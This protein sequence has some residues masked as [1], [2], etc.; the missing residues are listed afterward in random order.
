[1]KAKGVNASGIMTAS[2]WQRRKNSYQSSGQ[3]GAEVKNY[4]TYKAYLAAITEYLIE[5]NT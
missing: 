3:G 2:E 4:S 1:M 5:N